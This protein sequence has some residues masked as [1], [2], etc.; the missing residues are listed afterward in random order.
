MLES[1]TGVLENQ[2]VALF[3]VLDQDAEFAKNKT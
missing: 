2:A 3:N 1:Q